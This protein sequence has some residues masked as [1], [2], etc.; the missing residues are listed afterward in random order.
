MLGAICCGAEVTQLG[1]TAY[2]AE[3]RIPI[4][5]PARLAESSA[6]HLISKLRQ[7]LLDS[8]I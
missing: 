1:A 7:N 6:F 2:G 3:L 5:T 4:K 8:K